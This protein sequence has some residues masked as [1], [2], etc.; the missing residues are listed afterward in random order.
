MTVVQPKDFA[1]VTLVTP[2]AKHRGFVVD[3]SQL[4]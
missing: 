3:A 2:A 1:D 4:L